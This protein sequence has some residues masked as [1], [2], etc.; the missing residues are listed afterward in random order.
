[1]A[2]KDEQL[3]RRKAGYRRLNAPMYF[4]VTFDLKGAEGRTA[5]YGAF[6]R[7]LGKLLGAENTYRVIKQCYFV[8]SMYDIA[9]VRAEM[10]RELERQDSIIVVRLQPGQ[11]FR[12]PGAGRKA[13]EFFA[14]L[15]SDAGS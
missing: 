4:M 10:M 1:M 5:V 9:D 8:R 2:K 11:S 15:E 7:R 6:R 12:L 14:M 13:R 3:E